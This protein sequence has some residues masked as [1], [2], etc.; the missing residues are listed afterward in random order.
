MV[1]EGL[2]GLVEGVMFGTVGFFIVM[3]LSIVY[4]YFTNE[5]LSSFLGILFGL[6]VFGFA[7]G[8]LSILEEPTVGRAIS[9]V[10]ISI[11]TVWGVNTGDKMAEKMP[12]KSA[13]AILDGIR[14]GKTAYTTVKLPNARLIYDMAGKPRVPDALKDELAEREFTLPAD[15]PLED[16]TNRVKRRLI[17]DWGIG[18]VELE[19]DQ[20]SKV[21]HFAIAAK[22]RGLSAAIPE[23]SVAIPIECRVIPSNLAPGDSVKIFLE[24]NEVIEIIEVKGVN[25][26][27][28]VI[29]IV[30]DQSLLETFRDNKAS[31]VVALPSATPKSPAISVEQ[32]S[33][34]IEEFKLQKIINSLKKVGVTDEAAKQIV[35]KVQA[36]LSKMD[37]PISTRLI[38]TAVVEELEKENP[39]AAKKLKNRK[40]WDLKAF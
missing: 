19:L 13:S 27:Q 6:G 7:G 1:V 16:I 30:A 35:R 18:D 17:T 3:I 24:N 9:V 4:R 28:R 32:K 22:E 34:E 40:P 37:P 5:K 23:G 31:L 21:I 38:K 2:S 14:G 36:K 29:T 25:E 8:L 15:L 11:F 39:E 33:G 10:T 12:K 20:E 26:E